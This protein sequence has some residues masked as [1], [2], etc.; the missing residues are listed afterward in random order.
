MKKFVLCMIIVCAMLLCSCGAAAEKS[1]SENGISI[2]LTDDFAYEKY[3]NCDAC[4][5]SDKVTVYVFSQDFADVMGMEILSAKQ[6]A[7]AIASLNDSASEVTEKDGLAYYEY[8]SNGIDGTVYKNISFAFK[9]G[10][11][12]YTLQ[13]SAKEKDFSKLHDS[14][15]TYAATFTFEKA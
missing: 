3:D 12:F 4:F 5:K 8:T 13:F 7:E 11:E 10:S 9:G 15:F 2:T 6:Y 1:F 14:F